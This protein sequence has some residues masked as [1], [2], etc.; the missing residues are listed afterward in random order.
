MPTYENVIP[1]SQASFSGKL[2]R[3]PHNQAV[4][5]REYLTKAEVGKLMKVARNTGRHG[6]R[7]ATL[8]LMAYRHALRVSELVALRWEQIDLSQGLLHVVRRKNGVDCSHPLRGPE[9]RALRQLQRD[10]PET[11]YVF[12]TERNGP[13]TPSTVRKLM[14][15]ENAGT[16]FRF[17]RI[18]CVTGCLSERCDDL[19]VPMEYICD[20]GDSVMHPEADRKISDLLLRLEPSKLAVKCIE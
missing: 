20:R 1:L 10:Y 15:R 5:S 6:H 12:V 4:R 9:L 14:A 11:S 7:D 17:T 13:L 18:C 3:K 19:K 2:P 16:P 8:I